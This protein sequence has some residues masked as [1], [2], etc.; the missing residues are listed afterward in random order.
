MASFVEAFVPPFSFDECVQYVLECEGKPSSETGAGDLDVIFPEFLGDWLPLAGGSIVRFDQ[1]NWGLSA[2]EKVDSLVGKRLA[3]LGDLQLKNTLDSLNEFRMTLNRLLFKMRE[4]KVLE[5]GASSKPPKLFFSYY[6]GDDALLDDEKS[7]S[8]ITRMCKFKHIPYTAFN[9]ALSLVVPAEEEDDD[10]G[11]VVGA[12][13]KTF[14]E[15]L[16]ASEKPKESDIIDLVLE[17]FAVFNINEDDIVKSR[18]PATEGGYYTIFDEKLYIKMP[19]ITGRDS[20]GYYSDIFDK[21]SHFYIEASKGRRSYG[22]GEFPLIAL[23]ILATVDDAS[24]PLPDTGDVEITIDTATDAKDIKN[25]YLSILSVGQTVESSKRTVRFYSDSLEVFSIPMLTINDYFKNRE[26]T[27]EYDLSTKTD[28]IEFYIKPEE[29]GIS[30]GSDKESAEETGVPYLGG[31][32]SA[33]SFFGEKNRAEIVLTDSESPEAVNKNDRRFFSPKA[34]GAVPVLAGVRPRVHQ[35]VPTKWIEMNRAEEGDDEDKVRLLFDHSKFDVVNFDALSNEASF[36]LYLEDGNGQIIKAAGENITISTG[37]PTVTK[38]SPDGYKGSDEILATLKGTILRFSG[39]GL[40][41]A[42]GINVTIKGTDSVTTT[43]FSDPALVYTGSSTL[44]TLEC[45]AQ[46]SYI[47]LEPGQE[48]ELSLLSI[49]GESGNGNC[50]YVNTA[51]GEEQISKSKELAKFRIDEFSVRRFKSGYVSE[52]PVL[53]ETSAVLQLKSKQRLFT[54]NLDI[55]AYIGITDKDVATAI[56]GDD[57]LEVS[58]VGKTFYVPHNLEYE[59]SA[60]AS[61]DFSRKFF[62]ARADLSIPGSRY[63]NYNLFPLLNAPIGSAIIFYNK[64]IIE[65][66]PTGV[67]TPEDGD[68]AITWLGHND[69]RKPFVL[70]PTV[71]GLVAEQ[72]GGEG[73]TSTFTIEEKDA[74]IKKSFGG[75]TPDVGSISMF[76]NLTKLGIV[77]SCSKGSNL[78]RQLT[79]YIGKTKLSG[80]SEKIKDLGGGR[81]LAT[82]DNVSIKEEG[83]LEVRIEKKDK[84][85]RYTSSGVVAKRASFGIDAGTYAFNQDDGELTLGESSVNFYSDGAVD[86]DTN[87]ADLMIPG[88]TSGVLLNQAT[89]TEAEHKF[90]YPLTIRPNVSMKINI[91]NVTS[92][93][94]GAS[95]EIDDLERSY[96]Q[97][98]SGEVMTGRSFSISETGSAVGYLNWDLTNAATIK[99]N[100]P[101]I[102]LIKPT[103]EAANGFTPDKINGSL[104]TAGSEIKIEVENCKKNFKVIFNGLFAA[105][106]KGPPR[107][108]SRGKYEAVI[109]VPDAVIAFDCIEMCVSTANSRRLGA[110]L[111]MGEKFVQN[112]GKNMTDKLEGFMKDKTPDIDDLKGL[113][114]KFP[115]RFL[116]V[117]LDNSLVPLDLIKSF[118]DFSWH[119]TADLKI[120]LNGFQTLLIPIQ[121]ILCIIDVIC[122][123]LHPGKLAS[124][125]IRLF[126]CLYD[127]LLL[128]PQISVPVMFFSLILHLLNLLECVIVKIIETVVAINEI[129]KAIEIATQQQNLW[130][131]IITLEEVISEYLF[132]LNVDLD[133]LEPII[134]IL[135]IFLQILELIF[136]FPCPPDDGIGDKS[137]GIQGS[138]LAGMV[139]GKVSPGDGEYDPEALIPVA[140]YYTNDSIEDMISSN[141][142]SSYEEYSLGDSII[143][144][145][146]ESSYLEAMDIDPESLRTTN[147]EDFDAA[148]SVSFTKSTK[149]LGQPTLVKFKFK[150]KLDNSGFFKKK[151]LDPLLNRDAPFHLLDNDNGTLKI[152]SGKGNFISPLDGTKFITKDG[153]TGS[154]K[155]LTL[156]FEF[157]IMEP[158]PDTGMLEETGIEEV[159]RT[160][161]DIPKMA[162]MDEEGNLYFIEPDGIEFDSDNNIDQIKARIINDISAPKFRFTRD[163]QEVDTDDDDVP[164]DEGRVFDLPQLFFV[165]MRSIADELQNSCYAAS[166][167]EFLLENEETGDT[168]DI[169]DIVEGAVD[170][171]ETYRAIIRD[172]MKQVRESLQAGEI[173]D[174]M[175]LEAIAE[176]HQALIDCLTDSADSMCRFVMN[177]LNSSFLIEEDDDETPL[178]EYPE[179]FDPSDLDNID[180]EQSGPSFTGA[181]EFAGGIGDSHILDIG[182]VATIR[183]TPRDSYDIEMPGDLSDKIKI[184]ILSDSTGSAMILKN[185]DGT[186]IEQNG[187]DY[188]VRISSTN[189]GEVKLGAS[190]CG[191]T[192]A[193][194]TY[195]GITTTEEEEEVDCVPDAPSEVEEAAA[196]RPGALVKVDR[197]LTLYYVRLASTATIKLDGGKT[198]T[199]TAQTF[200]TALEN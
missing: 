26:P 9:I 199:S 5:S 72:P 176:A 7:S 183:V 52:I 92:L 57:V 185:D 38:V 44:S 97:V 114:K 78:R 166:Y 31:E 172:M 81:F 89:S 40:T 15:L 184:N 100:V 62:N 65:D 2:D 82:F 145:G 86:T 33:E 124:A 42:I 53:T 51:E 48:Y 177:P 8:S 54:G 37:L 135:A 67:V 151:V 79:F 111:A 169:A 178:A 148:F 192:I 171:I 189:E 193:A 61:A 77:F 12:S 142:G 39:E 120:A 136:N 22:R 90:L 159:T 168:D 3:D 134:S 131:A 45:S 71:L 191:R 87:A 101:E 179:V 110:K 103:I 160:F 32:Y 153:E 130:D 95:N 69:G 99:C 6:Q 188:Y 139:A 96:M 13:G 19:D 98:D 105:K 30:V 18:G 181:R 16:K 127:L 36:A 161:D 141:S 107:R 164:D 174:P 182:K 60:S 43:L 187:S 121:V 59:F 163:D 64:R 10:F 190:V 198:A 113:I 122:S 132:E 4:F 123:L 116:Q 76:Q 35:T 80:L 84:V 128:L 147:G 194:V 133:V 49:S 144:Q 28:D 41:N 75:A 50:V 17:M 68:Y 196:T 138:M 109:T 115:L 195:A 14:R 140:Q 156:T 66:A 157:P 129:I 73:L 143:D 162:I 11:N 152:A 186:T 102:T 150:D 70:G 74:E 200:G 85:F 20:A 155:P 83:V 47:G 23:P 56:G 180:V 146:T 126:Y 197:V 93:I 112:I 63:Q 94:G 104:L 158:N 46:L 106:T 91:S 27:I 25:A 24:V 1:S 29:G 154:V 175:D 117:K 108:I 137:C 119:L 170:C 165:D 88:G 167:N 149:G 125:V 173:P 118:C 58:A 21:D 55:F 34:Y